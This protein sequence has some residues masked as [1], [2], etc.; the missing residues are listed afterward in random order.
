M[1]QLFKLIGIYILSLFK[2]KTQVEKLLE[3]NQVHLAT[4][5]E[6]SQLELHKHKGDDGVALVKLAIDT[7]R[8]ITV[9]EVNR[10]KDKEN[11]SYHLGRLQALVDL[12]QFIDNAF[13]DKYYAL[14]RGR[15]PDDLK[16]KILKK[17]TGHKMGPVI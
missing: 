8:N 17:A 7:A 11:L 9:L 15:N 3:F 13:D 2:P 1:V 10:V 12:G 4:K 16:P 5:M 14:L 6:R